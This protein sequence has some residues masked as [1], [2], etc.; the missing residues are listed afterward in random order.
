M[1]ETGE[2]KGHSSRRTSLRCQTD[3]VETVLEDIARHAWGAPDG[4]WGNTWSR[5]VNID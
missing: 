1:W 3:R 5:P 4:T 2:K